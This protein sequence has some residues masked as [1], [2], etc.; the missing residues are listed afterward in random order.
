MEA[1]ELKEVLLLINGLY[2]Q[3]WQILRDVVEEISNNSAEIIKAEWSDRFKRENSKWYPLILNKI[4]TWSTFERC[5][6]FTFHNENDKL[7]CDVIIWDGNSYDGHPTNERFRVDLY[8]P[9]SFILKLSDRI[10]YKLDSLIEDWY[11][12]YL[13]KKKQ[14]WMKNEKKKLLNG[15]QF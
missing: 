13:E 9:D 10:E 14:D 15:K 3:N 6:H 5:V 7:R 4:D 2:V 12:D 11:E 1:K 8:L